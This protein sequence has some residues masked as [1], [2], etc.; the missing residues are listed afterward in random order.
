[1]RTQTHCIDKSLNVTLIIFTSAYK[2]DVACCRFGSQDG[3]LAF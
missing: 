2:C 1:M 3:Y